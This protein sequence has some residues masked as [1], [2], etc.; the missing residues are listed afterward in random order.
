MWKEIELESLISSRSDQKK[1]LQEKASAFASKE[2]QMRML[3]DSQKKLSEEVVSLNDR[4]DNFKLIEVYLAQY[5]DERQ[6]QVYR[7]IEHTVTEGLRTVFE[8]DLRLEIETKMVGAR[9]ETH[10]NIVSQTSKGELATSIMD[11]RGGGVAAIV[12]FLVQAVLVLLTPS[13]RP[14]LFLDETFR[15]VSEEYQA[16]LGEFIQD[17]CKRTGLQVVLVTHQPTIAEYASNW[18]SFSQENGKTKI[19]KVV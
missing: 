11:S 12:G 8:E 13:L 17:L 18:Y 19:K 3:Q 9:S 16:P 15:N 10:F 2:G 4:I 6:A 1:R 5:A 7:Q 14:I